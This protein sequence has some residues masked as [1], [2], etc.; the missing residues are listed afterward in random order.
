[1][2]KHLFP[3]VLSLCLLGAFSLTGCDD[4]DDNDVSPG[5]ETGE[6]SGHEG[7]HRALALARAGVKSIPVLLFDSSNKYISQ[8]S[9]SLFHVKQSC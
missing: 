4:K 8:M 6:I 1:M 3:K 2:K 9:A 7:R 5:H